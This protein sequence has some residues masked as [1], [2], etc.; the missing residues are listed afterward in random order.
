MSLKMEEDPQ[1]PQGGSSSTAMIGDPALVAPPAP[2]RGRCWHVLHR[3]HFES[4][5]LEHMYLRYIYSLH[6]SGVQSFVI[7]FVIVCAVLAVLNF[8]FVS[9]TTVE[10]ICYIALCVAYVLLLVFM[11]TSFMKPPIMFTLSLIV[12]VLCSCFV[13][14]SM[15]INYANRPLMQFTPAEGVWQVAWVVFMVYSFLP[16]RIYVAMTTGLVVTAAHVLV[17]IF[18]T[19]SQDWL[20]WRQ[21]GDAF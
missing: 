12:L 6:H 18:E 7:L 4:P 9:H 16:L 1:H 19:S 21:V 13:V 14:I 17:S 20:L 5:E 15:P 10:N 8:V 3:H 2:G 11:H